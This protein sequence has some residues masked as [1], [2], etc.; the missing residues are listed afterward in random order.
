MDKN[1]VFGIGPLN[2]MDH[3]TLHGGGIRLLFHQGIGA[4]ISCG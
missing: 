3:F 4:N 1:H 2:F